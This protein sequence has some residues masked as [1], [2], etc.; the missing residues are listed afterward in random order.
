MMIALW[1]DDDIE[2]VMHADIHARGADRAGQQ[3]Q[4]RSDRR[5]LRGDARG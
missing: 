2:W 5:K 3:C 1:A 4:G